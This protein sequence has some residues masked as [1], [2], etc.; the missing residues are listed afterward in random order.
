MDCVIKRS[1]QRPGWWVVADRDNL[2]VVLFEEHKY[3]ETKEVVFL[4]DPDEYEEM[5]PYSPDRCHTDK[6]KY[7]CLLEWLLNNHRGLI[8]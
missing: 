5:I 7:V 8:E 4:I 2:I 1:V 6:Y 3:A